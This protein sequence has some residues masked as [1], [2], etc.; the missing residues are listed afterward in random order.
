MRCDYKTLRNCFINFIK[1]RYAP[2]RHIHS[3]IHQQELSDT[4]LNCQLK[5]KFA[6]NFDFLS[7]FRGCLLLEFTYWFIDGCLQCLRLVLHNPLD[8]VLF[9]PC[10]NRL[11]TPRAWN[12]Q[13]LFWHFYANAFVRKPLFGNT[14]YNLQPCLYCAHCKRVSYGPI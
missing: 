4:K 1:S 3:G 2:R 11:T 9:N 8:A 10:V 6:E 5:Q 13:N 12:W 7:S 14:T